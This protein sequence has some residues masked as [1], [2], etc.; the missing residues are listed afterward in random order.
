MAGELPEGASFAQ[1]DAVEVVAGPHAGERGAVV[2]LLMLQPEPLYLVKL[3][4][5]GRDVRV[6]QSRL[7]RVE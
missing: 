2:L 1:N 5:T 7:R 3:A 4:S 6:R